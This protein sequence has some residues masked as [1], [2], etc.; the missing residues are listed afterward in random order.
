M[1]TWLFEQ[2]FIIKGDGF[3]KIEKI[4]RE[5]K[6]KILAKKEELSYQ[7]CAILLNDILYFSK[8][9]MPIYEYVKQKYGIDVELLKGKRNLPI[10]E[11]ED[12]AFYIFTE[13]N[14]RIEKNK[15]EFNE[16]LL[17]DYDLTCKVHFY[18]TSDNVLLL[19]ETKQN[20]Y[21][22]II[23]D[24]LEVHQFY[25]D[26][27]LE[28]PPYGVS[29]IDWANRAKEWLSILNRCGGAEN[30]MPSSGSFSVEMTE[31]GLF[32]PDSNEILK[33]MDSFKNI[34]L[35]KVFDVMNE[36]GNGKN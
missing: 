30:W 13:L 15:E 3:Y 8:L 20:E 19:V 23:G 17:D 32:V 25:F 14:Q 26:V 1:E 36:V 9:G 34:E 28:E 31:N 22:E 21:L 7:K 18:P 16:D 10:E 24:H 27:S 35:D 33:Y 5:L 29:H 6:E 11:L 12:Y 4:R 2:G